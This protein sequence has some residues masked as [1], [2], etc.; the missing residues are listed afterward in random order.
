ME[1]SSLQRHRLTLWIYSGY[2]SLHCMC[3]HVRVSTERH[4]ERRHS[5]WPCLSLL[6]YLLFTDSWKGGSMAFRCVPIDNPT[7]LKW[8]GPI[9]WSYR[10]LWL[11]ELV[12]MRPNQKSSILERD[13]QA[14]RSRVDKNRKEIKEV[15]GVFRIY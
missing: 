1:C 12:L 14:V 4:E 13:Q 11:N 9:Q 15:V 3:T 7:R 2:K 10:C 8:L 5:G 6:N